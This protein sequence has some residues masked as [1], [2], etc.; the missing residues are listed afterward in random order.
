MKVSE[1][2]ILKEFDGY[3]PPRWMI[4][5][6]QSI[7]EKNS[8]KVA[9]KFADYILDKKDPGYIVSSYIIRVDGNRYEIGI[10]RTARVGS[11]ESFTSHELF[12][13]FKNIKHE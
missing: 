6:I 11:C 5:I 7:C 13:I 10:W 2:E 4:E 12:E 3:K 8:E 1:E 9:V